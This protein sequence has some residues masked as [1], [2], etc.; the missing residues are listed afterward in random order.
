MK[1][2]LVKLVRDLTYNTTQLSLDKIIED[3]SE[4][5]RQ[6]DEYAKE[7]EPESDSYRDAQIAQ[8]AVY[9]LKYTIEH[10]VDLEASVRVQGE[11]IRK[12]ETKV[13]NLE[14]RMSR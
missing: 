12:L 11:Y 4:H 13:Q 10:L 3:M 9:F 6:I 1:P 5:S 14:L 7:N 2:D 8:M